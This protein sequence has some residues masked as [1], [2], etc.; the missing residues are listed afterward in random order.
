VHE[1]YFGL[2]FRPFAE[3]VD[4]SAFVPLPS[5]EAIV[6]RLRY[7]LE[8]GDGPVLL[9]G[10]VGCGKS[11]VAR[12]LARDL[13]W[14]S[15]HVVFPTMGASDLVT[16]LS[17]ELGAPPAAAPGLA[18]AVRRLQDELSRR[19]SEGTRTLLVVDESHLIDN[20]ATFETLRLFTNFATDGSPDLGLV[21]V[22][23]PDVRLAIPPALADRLAARC[24]LGPLDSPETSAYLSGRLARAGRTESL[25]DH[26]C[27][28]ALHRAAEGSPRRLN[29]LADLCLLIAYA[30]DKT[31]PDARTV[32][33]AT[34]EAGFDLLVA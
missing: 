14:P 8:F 33:L 11:L 6:R 9:M 4:P 27:V 21:L 13:G 10:P 29:R 30:Q 16:Y 23:D 12:V 24:Y 25:F 3:T 34:R 31:R 5:H 1:S 20:P 22:G 7:G 15:A 18:G 17:D 2:A 28:A 19:A 32:A 26:E